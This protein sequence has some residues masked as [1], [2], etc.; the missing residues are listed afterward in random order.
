M[1]ILF[2][3]EDSINL[4]KLFIRKYCVCVILFLFFGI[5]LFFGFLENIDINKILKI[6]IVGM[7]IEFL[8]DYFSFFIK[9]CINFFFY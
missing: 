9:K 5:L 4:F 6:K 8:M 7:D 2:Y 3:L 1:C